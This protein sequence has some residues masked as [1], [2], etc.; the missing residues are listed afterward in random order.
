MAY[1][2]PDSSLASLFDAEGVDTDKMQNYYLRV[3]E[4]IFLVVAEELRSAGSTEQ[5]LSTLYD[6]KPTLAQKWVHHLE[7]AREANDPKQTNRD[8]I[9]R[10]V[11]DR[12]DRDEE[13]VEQTV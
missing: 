13:G 4:Y 6:D 2:P 5:S 9:Y 8:H 12:F 11:K 3:L 7:S 1:P 10:K